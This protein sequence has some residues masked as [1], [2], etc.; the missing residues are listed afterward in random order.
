MKRPERFMMLEVK[1]ILKDLNK[2]KAECKKALTLGL[3]LQ[4]RLR[5]CTTAVPII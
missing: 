1:I 2:G 5:R 4:P 3:T